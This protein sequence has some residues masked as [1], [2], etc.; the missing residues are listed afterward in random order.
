ML[1][2]ENKRSGLEKVIAYALV[3][4]FISQIA[5]RCFVIHKRLTRLIQQLSNT[6]SES[7]QRWKFLYAKLLPTSTTDALGPKATYNLE[8][9]VLSRV[10]KIINIVILH[11]D[12]VGNTV[13]TALLLVVCFSV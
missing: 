1:K 9:K 7:G 8:H 11:N 3:K 6:F 4:H 10:T 5:N 12:N 2:L 13:I